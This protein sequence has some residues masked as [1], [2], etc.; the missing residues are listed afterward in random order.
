MSIQLGILI[1]LLKAELVALGGE[2]ITVGNTAVGLT[3][4]AYA[5]ADLAIVSVEDAP[6]RYWEHGAN[7]TATVGQLVDF[8]ERFPLLSPAIL[9]GFRAIRASGSDS[10]IAVTYYRK[11]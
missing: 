7:P 10:S 5:G 3:P 4:A 8:D 1:D 2:M 11:G 9:V 6:I